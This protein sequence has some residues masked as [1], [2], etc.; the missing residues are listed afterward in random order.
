MDNAAFVIGYALM[1][2]GGSA[3]LIVILATLWIWAINRVCSLLKIQR[4]MI[5][6]LF[7]KQ[8]RYGG[9]DK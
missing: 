3:I 4:A 1:L 2:L 6:A 8:G 9:K 5:A 7:D